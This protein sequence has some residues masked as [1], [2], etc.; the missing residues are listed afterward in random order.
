MGKCFVM[1]K[2]TI[3]CFN[4]PCSTCT[5]TNAITRMA[6]QQGTIAL[7]FGILLFICYYNLTK[8]DLHRGYLFRMRITTM[9]NGHGHQY[10]HQNGVSP[11]P[12]H[13]LLWPEWRQQPSLATPPSC[14]STTCSSG[15]DMAWDALSQALVCFCKFYFF[16]ISLKFS[17]PQSSA[18]I[19]W[20]KMCLTQLKPRIW[21][22]KMTQLW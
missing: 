17:I 19:L 4:L 12:W 11:Y 18:T 1:H 15:N 22:R 7:N 10:N 2:Q 9:T 3:V 16:N 14:T 13:L 5:T 20:L 6:L 8:D 21:P